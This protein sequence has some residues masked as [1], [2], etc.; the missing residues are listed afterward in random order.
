[1][2]DFVSEFWNVYIAAA[3]VVSILACA[4]LLWSVSSRKVTKDAKGQTATSGHVWDEDITEYNNPLPMWWMWM[5]YLTIFFSAGYLVLYPGLGSFQGTLGW[6]SVNEHD[7][8]V[9]KAEAEFGPLFKQ[10]LEK[11]LQTV[12]ADPRAHAIGE[13]LFFNYCAQCHGSD[14]RGSKGFPDL[15]DRDWLW[16]GTPEQIAQTISAGRQGVMPPMA[17]AVGTPEDVRHLAH[18]VLSLSGGPHD[19]LA[20][21][22]GRS[23]FSTCAA[24]HGVNGKG[25]TAL[26]APNLADKTWLHGWGEQAVVAMVTQ[27]RSNV[28]PAHAGRLSPPQIKVLAAYVWQLSQP[29]AKAAQ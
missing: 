27:G 3:T 24:C 13:R 21:Q 11:D 2:A 8:E 26:G 1:M 29:A 22:L 23:K 25:N 4:L 20:A 10:F 15:T 16:G 17:T 18:Y 9:A 28:M 5:F 19:S 12:A 6:T 14:A 7:A